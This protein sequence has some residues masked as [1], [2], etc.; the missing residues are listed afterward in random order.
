MKTSIPLILILF[1]SSSS[2]CE[3]NVLRDD[4]TIIAEGTPGCVRYMISQLKE[5]DVRNPPA[6]VWKVECQ[7]KSYFYV[8]SYCCDFMSELYDDNCKL[9]C[10]PDGGFAGNGDGKCPDELDLNNKVLVWQD[11]RSK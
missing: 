9:I 2:G 3:K 8:P 6:S 5:I 4:D 10:H 7:A 11:T 1:L